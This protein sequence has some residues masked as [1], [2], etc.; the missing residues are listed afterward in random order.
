M[1]DPPSIKVL[2]ADRPGF[3]RTALARLL[4]EMPG[5][6]LVR[7]LGKRDLIE[8]AVEETRPDVLVIDDRLLR[9]N[10]WTGRDLGV[11]LI[12]VGVDDDPGFAARATHRRGGLGS[13]GAG[14]RHPPA[15]AQATQTRQPVVLAGR[16]VGSSLARRRTGMLARSCAPSRVATRPQLRDQRAQV[17]D[18]VR[19]HLERLID[20]GFQAHTVLAPA[21]ARE[22]HLHPGELLQGCPPQEFRIPIRAAYG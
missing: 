5:V 4:E 7:K 17:L 2:L 13:E 16:E 19:D 3:S 6:N 15:P 14:G 11:R 18:A 10:H 20:R 1:A 12:V 21:R 8:P 22:Q 9:D